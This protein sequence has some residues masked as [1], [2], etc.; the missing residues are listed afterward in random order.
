MNKTLFCALCCVS[1]SGFSTEK[2]PVDDVVASAARS[3]QNTQRLERHVVVSSA[4]KEV[5]GFLEPWVQAKKAL[6]PLVMK[7]IPLYGERINLRL[8]EPQLEGD[9]VKLD[10]LR[11]NI[12][13]LEQELQNQLTPLAG[14]LSSST[15]SDLYLRLLQTYKDNFPAKPKAS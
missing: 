10:S 1:I 5:C 15:F 6:T 12:A 14:L 8:V 4:F 13:A 2:L 7:L 3:S 9:K 11:K